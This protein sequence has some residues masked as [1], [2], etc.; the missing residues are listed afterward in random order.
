MAEFKAT[1]T[2]TEVKINIA[3]FEPAMALKG[4]IQRELMKMDIKLDL[5]TEI[6]NTLLMKGLM[7]VDSSQEVMDALFKCLGGSTYAGQRITPSTFNAAEPRK[8][9]YEVAMACIKENLS[10]FFSS[11]FSQLS[12]VAE[13][14]KKVETSLKSS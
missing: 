11:L 10:P 8:D 2:G 4:A 7:A 12:T 5:S 3:D 9:F 1:A 14:F 13:A 6:D